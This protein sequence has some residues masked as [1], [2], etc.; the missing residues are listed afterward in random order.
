M[1]CTAELDL[2]AYLVLNLVPNEADRV[3][4]REFDGIALVR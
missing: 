3:A 2:S 1:I 4:D